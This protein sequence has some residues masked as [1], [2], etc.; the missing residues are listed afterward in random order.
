MN[1]HVIVDSASDLE[2][3]I[4]ENLTVLPITFSFGETEYLDGVTL[5]H[6]EFYEKLI[7]CD[8]L[9][10]TSQITPYIYEEAIEN[11]LTGAD[12]V[13]IIT[14][15]GKLS[16]CY[17]SAVT[18][19]SEYS[20]KVFVIDSENVSIAEQILVTHALNMIKEGND[21]NT[22]VST[23]NSVKKKIRII[24]LLDTL[25]YL[26][27]GGRISKAVAFAGG[28]LSIKPVVS[29]VEG[30]VVLLGKARGS[31]QGNNFLNNETGNYGGVDY[32]MPL[33]LGYTGLDTTLINKYIEDSAH[34]LENY[35]YPYPICS[36]G[37]TIG[38]HVGPGAIT[39]AWYS[40][41]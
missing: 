40:K 13:I 22:I 15:S 39:V 2:N 20:D 10:K 41:D 24:A 26:Q 28:I 6:K 25:D 27:K 38:T 18:A 30:E 11:A 36:I 8:T 14:L 21:I 32:S 12:Y 5:S 9:P 29:V 31:K 7:E 3:G 1:I 34:L 35:P 33:A 19:A 17:Q 37:G 23:L 4:D 16:G